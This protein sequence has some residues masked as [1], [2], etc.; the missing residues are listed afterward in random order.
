MNAKLTPGLLAIALVMAALVGP[1]TEM[2]QVKDQ[3]ALITDAVFWRGVGASAI[4]S[5]ATSA[6]TLIALLSTTLGLPALFAKWGAGQPGGS[7]PGSG[8]SAPRTDTPPPGG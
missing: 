3:P 4:G 2:Q 1:L 7:E 8:S 5:F 6:L